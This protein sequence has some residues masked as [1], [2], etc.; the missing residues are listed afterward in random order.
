MLFLFNIISKSRSFV[1]FSCQIKKKL[2][3]CLAREGNFLA[4]LKHLA[5]SGKIA[6][7]VHKNP[8]TAET[9]QKMF[10]AGELASAETRNPR[11]LLQT[12]WFYISLYF[13]NRGRENQSAMKKSMLPLAV[14]PSGEEY[15]E[16]NKEEAGA[17]LST[18]NH[19]GGL[20]GTED[21]A[22]GKIFASP[23]SSRCPLQTIKAYLCHLHPEVDALFQRPKEISLRFDP[24]KDK[25]WFE[26]KVLGHNSLENMM[27]NMTERAVILQYYTNH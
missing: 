13:G 4:C 21:H 23:N 16:L 7:T 8:L 11:L 25:I 15:F 5:S 24:E 10:E 14:T 12:T 3:K 18:K 20:D 2:S 22:D 27:R 17:V 26:R 9:V 1:L 19:T 6:G